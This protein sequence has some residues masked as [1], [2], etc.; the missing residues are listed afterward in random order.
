VTATLRGEKGEPRHPFPGEAA[1]RLVSL[2]RAIGYGRPLLLYYSYSVMPEAERYQQ[3]EVLR[4]GDGS[5]WELGR[6]AM[7]ITYKA[8]DTN[9]HCTV[10]LKVINSTYLQNDTARQRFLREARAAAALRHPNVAS[11]FNLSTVEDNYFYVMEFIDG[12]TVDACVKRK[13]HLEPEEALNIALQV[14]RALAAAA[15]Q[16]L[17]HRDL[18][19]SNLMLVD[20]E[21][22]SVVKVI[23]FG[24]AKSAKDAGEDTGT[25]TMGGFVGTPHFA[26][27]EQVEEG[28]LDVRSDIYSLGA[29]LYFMVAGKAPFSGSVGQVM[30]QHLYKPIAI[31]PLADVPRCVVSLIQRMLEKDRNQR[32]QTPR[33][34]Q[35][36]IVDCLGEIRGPSTR[37][38][39]G[40]ADEPPQPLSPGALLA[41]N[42]RLI[43]ELRESPQGRHFLAEDVRRKRLVCLLILSQEL[44]SDPQW[45]TRLQLAVER[46]RNASHPTLRAIY[47]LERAGGYSILVEEHVVGPSLLDLLRSRSVLN[48]PEV[49]RLLN[50]LAPL[51]DHAR[52]NQLEHVD[53][54]LSGILF[55]HRGSTVSAIQPDLLR[56]PLTAWEQVEPKVN[57]IDFSFA[58]SQTGTLTGLET[59]TQSA[60]AGA[61]RGS[62]VRALSLLAYELLGGPRD[63]VEA[64]GRYNPIAALTRDGNAVLR[65][66]L[67]DEWSSAAELAGQ[68]AAAVG[69]RQSAAPVPESTAHVTSISTERVTPEPLPRTPLPETPADLRPKRTAMVSAWHLILAIGL[70][71]AVGIGGYLIY[72]SLNQSREIVA[73]SQELAALSVQ[74]DPAGASILL[75]GKPP[76]GPANTF[77]HVPFGTHRLT[78][79]LDNYEP[80]KQDIEVRSGMAPNIP[81]KLTPIQE[82]AALSVQSDPAGASILLDGKPPQ[83]PSNTFSHVPFGT[84]QLTATLNDYEPIKQDLEV[85]RGMTPELHLKLKPSQEIA[86]LSV[87]S[88]PAGASILLDG[89]PPSGPSNT[90]THVPFGTHQLTATLNDYEPIKQDLEVRRGMAPEIHLKLKQSQEIASLSVQSDPPG[91]SILLDGKPA[92]GPSNTFS[93]VPFGTH[94]LI[95]T[96]NDYEPLNQDLEVR[97]GMAPEIHLKLKQSQEFAALSVQSDPPGASILLDGKP[98]QMSPNTFTHIPFGTHQLAATLENY[99]SIKQEI[100]IRRGMNPEIRL[101]FNK[102]ANPIAEFVAETKKYDESSPQYLTAYVRLVQFVT[103]SKAAN[104]GEYTKELGRIIERLRTKAPPIGKNEFSISF[105]ESIKDAASLDILPAIIWLAENEKGSE[106]LSLFLR[107]ANLGDSYAMMR[108]GRFYLNEGTPSDDDK[109]FGWLKRAYESPDSNLDAGAY[110]GACYLSGR[111]TKKDVQKAE[112]IILPLA[113]RNVIS[114]MTIAGNLLEYRAADKQKEAE[115]ST[116]PL[117]RKQPLNAEADELDREAR[118]WYERAAAKGDWNASAR[119]GR[120]YENG[121]GGLEKSDEEAERR[122]QEGIKQENALSMFFYGQ[123]LIEKKPDR[124]G[125]AEKLMSQA[126]AKGV[127]SAIKW[128]KE[129]NVNFTEETPGSDRQ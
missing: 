104:S 25:L 65:R 119:L 124:R 13:G 96:L 19:P 84:H 70:I 102:K 82:I 115:S 118:K 117:K 10:A 105:K 80:I 127:P 103:T 34:L 125:E 21:G 18:K 32:P 122:Y 99:E 67:I 89:K 83:R 45:F 27:P 46:L 60:G 72:L 93:H 77:T 39:R 40:A 126:A 112:E 120:F 78:A 9:L 75:D 114:A 95:A 12:E 109:A 3:Y 55:V 50:L 69:I 79:T 56:R 7:G 23:D 73:P 1:L 48:A 98:P 29:T 14:A 42:Y 113:N 101:K 30:S 41:Q 76:T 107:A 61:P 88:D 8:Y 51:A 94:Q 49:V 106:S 74:S 58:P 11:V 108:M 66:G 87:Q 57:P 43:E 33:D 59:R 90:F 36:A 16:R 6:G 71:A 92:P 38:G 54:T 4:R 62:G 44:V 20:E 5:L 128:C 110:L 129:N 47:S 97:R 35:N 26:S 31:E 28:D 111:G 85:R 53:L 81:L 15:K 121:W 24:L 64:T 91:A 22:E 37:D 100:E 63:R 123:F 52:A 68:L 2:G 17:V 116:T 86:S